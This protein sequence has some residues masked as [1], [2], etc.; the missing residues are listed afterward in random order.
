MDDCII[1]QIRYGS[2]DRWI[3]QVLSMF[4]YTN[5]TLIPSSTSVGAKF[6]WRLTT[7]LANCLTCITYFGWSESASR[8]F[9]HLAT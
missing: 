5:P 2:L 4:I 6:L 8:I 3:S 1:E 7:N 9:V